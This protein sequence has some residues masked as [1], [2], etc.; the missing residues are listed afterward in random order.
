MRDVIP[1]LSRLFRFLANRISNLAGEA[2]FILS[3][4][5]FSPVRAPVK[6]RR[7]RDFEPGESGDRN[8]Y[9]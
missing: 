4:V 7:S 1:L 8:V 9:F 3:F 5:C 2:E 6:I